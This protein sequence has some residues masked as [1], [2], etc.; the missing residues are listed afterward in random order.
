MKEKKLNLYRVPMSKTE[1][2]YAYIRTT[3]MKK[4]QEKFNDDDIDH[5]EYD[6]D[7]QGIDPEFGQDGKVELY[8]EDVE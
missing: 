7:T 4:A 3:S 5:I 6:S 8:D 2:A 1:G